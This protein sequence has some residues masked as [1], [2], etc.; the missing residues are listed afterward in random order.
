[1]DLISNLNNRGCVK[2]SSVDDVV[3]LVFSCH[4]SSQ[5]KKKKENKKPLWKDKFHPEQSY[6]RLHSLAV[7]G[8]VHLQIIRVIQHFGAEQIV[9]QVAPQLCKLEQLTVIEY[10]PAGRKRHKRGILK[11]SVH[12]IS[13]MF[14]SK[15]SF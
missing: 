6:S 3:A 7:A 4:L 2:T 14:F 15:W 10:G 13:Q 5:K 12:P 1:M 8:H 9:L 11:E